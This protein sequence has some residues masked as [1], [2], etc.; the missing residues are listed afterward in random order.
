MSRD[1]ARMMQNVEGLRM[2]SLYSTWAGFYISM[3]LLVA[4]TMWFVW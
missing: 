4:A 2:L 3:Y 1:G